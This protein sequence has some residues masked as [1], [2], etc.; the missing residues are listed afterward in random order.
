MSF[1]R[2]INEYQEYETNFRTGL[3]LFYTLIHR[4][5]E[6]VRAYGSGSVNFQIQISSTRTKPT[7]ICLD[8]FLGEGSSGS[9]YRIK[10]NNRPAVIKS[11]SDQNVLVKEVEMLRFLNDS[12]IQNIPEY[13]AHDVKSIIIYPDC[14][15]V[16]KQF[17]ATHARELLQVLERIHSLNIFI[18]MYDHR[19]SC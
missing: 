19:I 18:E 11:I 1:N 9:V 8:E 14:K 15:R 3:W 2:N 10:W 17:Q 4:G 16:D 6:Y 5:S 7:G 12:N 13:V